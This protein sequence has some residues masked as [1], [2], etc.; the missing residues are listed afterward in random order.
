MWFGVK[1]GMM[2]RLAVR[3]SMSCTWT[4]EYCVL[5]VVVPNVVT[6]PVDPSAVAPEVDVD[7]DVDVVVEVEDDVV[8]VVEDEVVVV[9]VDEDEVVDVVED[10]DDEV[11]VVDVLVEVVDEEVVDDVVDEDV[12]VEL[13][14]VVKEKLLFNNIAKSNSAILFYEYSTATTLNP[15][16]DPPF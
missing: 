13:E 8:V 16:A 3:R 10:D 11:V 15:P 14:V 4:A 7:V 9:V 6:T 2:Y 12:E 1:Y 5:V